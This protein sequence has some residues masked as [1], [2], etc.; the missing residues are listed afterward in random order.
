VGDQVAEHPVGIDA[1][2]NTGDVGQH[3]IQGDGVAVDV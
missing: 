3:R 2:P 1:R